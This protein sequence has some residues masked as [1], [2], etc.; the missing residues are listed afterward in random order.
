MNSFNV[1]SSV[2]QKLIH[3]QF[4]IKELVSYHLVCEILQCT[5]S[6]KRLLEGRVGWVTT[7]YNFASI[8]TS[9]TQLLI[10]HVV[11]K[12]KEKEM[13]LAE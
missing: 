5:L 10:P 1:S 8:C 4:D 2:C 11:R 9:K 3:L 7:F 6:S 13:I 12:E